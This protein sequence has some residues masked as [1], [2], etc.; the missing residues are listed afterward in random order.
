MGRGKHIDLQKAMVETCIA[1]ENLEAAANA[2]LPNTPTLAAMHQAMNQDPALAA[3]MVDLLEGL[4][5][6][7]RSNT[8]QVESIRQQI[9]RLL[10]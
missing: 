1:Y 5:K 4:N 9:A 7:A 6:K 8:H 3:L 10:K 2:A